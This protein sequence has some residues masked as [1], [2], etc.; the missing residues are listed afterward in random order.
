LDVIGSTASDTLL[1]TGTAA[2]FGNTLISGAEM[3][4]P[5]STAVTFL[6]ASSGDDIDAVAGTVTL[7]G[8][9]N[10]T[11]GGP[12][13]FVNAGATVLFT[14]T[15]HLSAL[16][17]LSPVE[18]REWCRTAPPCWT[19]MR[20]PQPQVFQLAPAP[21]TAVTA[22]YSGGGGSVNVSWTGGSGNQSYVVEEQLPGGQ[23]TPVATIP[24]LGGI[25]RWAVFLSGQRNQ[26][27]RDLR[28]DRSNLRRAVVCLDTPRGPH[29][30][31][32]PRLRRSRSP[33]PAC[34]WEESA[35]SL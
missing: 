22:T 27:Q 24:R 28:G 29:K 9:P 13:V 14:G 25:G 30:P 11:S 20:C 15:Q 7:A 16:E 1:T 10:L 26:Q 12:S 33:P 18:P 23:W 32:Q 34:R 8:D 3:R 21:P 17:H 6:N 35:R 5:A 19:P 4:Y 31:A 2:V